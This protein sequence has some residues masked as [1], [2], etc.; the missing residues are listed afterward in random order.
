MRKAAEMLSAVAASMP[1]TEEPAFK[2]FRPQPKDQIIVSKQDSTFVVSSV[3]AKRL[4]A[5]T[6]L[7]NPEALPLL[8]RQLTRIGVTKALQKAGV[9]SGDLVR[10]GTV[11]LRW[12]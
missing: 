11:E 8:K 2:V 4:V 9:K 5:M 3:R 7:G 6:D 10:F 1:K 12:E